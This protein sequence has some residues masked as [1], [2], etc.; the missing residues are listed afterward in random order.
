MQNLFA[1]TIVSTGIAFMVANVSIGLTLYQGGTFSCASAVDRCLCHAVNAKD[2][3]T[4][5]L[6]SWKSVRLRAPG[7]AGVLGCARKCHFRGIQ[8]V[9]ADVYD[10]E[11][12]HGAHIHCFVKRATVY[13]AFAEETDDDLTVLAQLGTQGSPRCQRDGSAHNSIRAHKAP[14]GSI[15]M[16][17]P[18]K[19]TRASCH[20]AP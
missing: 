17:A 12:P 4:V 11:V 5:D 2:I 6:Y 9:L 20:L 7:Y 8:I 13:C 1:S 19:S 16:H 10:R 15:H 3:L 14:F 18:A